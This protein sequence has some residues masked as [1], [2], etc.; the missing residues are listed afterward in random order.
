MMG[1]REMEWGSQLNSKILTGVALAA[2]LLGVSTSGAWATELMPSFANVPTGWTVDRYAPDSF[3][4]VGT[5]QGVTNVLGIG[6]GPNGATANRPASQQGNFYSTQGEGYDISGGAGDSIAAA[7]YVPRTWDTPSS[8]A[9]RT[10]MWG[11]M[12]D[13]TNVTDY[14]IIG[15]TN[16]GTGGDLNSSG[17]SDNYI[18]FRV[19]SETFN[20]GSGG[21]YDLPGTVNY[22]A[23]NDLVMQ[24]TGTGYN[25]FING[26]NVLNTPAGP[27]TTSFSR[28]LMQALNFDGDTYYTDAVANPYTAHWANS[29]VP[30]PGSLALV[31]PGLLALGFLLWRKNMRIRNRAVA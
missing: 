3:A 22:G 31:A 4:N 13:G 10:D 7:L 12:T 25:Y 15:F 5:Y 2:A 28:V 24:F 1:R 23:W 17:S 11:V 6:I 8:G 16:V 18:G 29:P 9:R 14:P 27:G 20:S 19:W 30:E 26:V 21:W